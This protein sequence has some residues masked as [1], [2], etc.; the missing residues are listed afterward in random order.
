MTVNG[1][2]REVFR[3]GPLRHVNTHD[4]VKTKFKPGRIPAGFPLINADG[5]PK[6]TLAPVGAPVRLKQG[7]PRAVYQHLK[8][9]HKSVGLEGA[10]AA[11][12]PEAA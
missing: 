7:S 3:T 8:R 12:T 6:A 5:T 11:L 10:V 2:P 4:V 9:L 1:L